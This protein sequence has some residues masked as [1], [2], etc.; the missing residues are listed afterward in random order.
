MLKVGWSL[1]LTGLFLGY[2]PCL[3]TCGP[4]LI[5]YIAATK[6]NAGKGFRTYLIFSL[7][8]VFVYLILGFL[9]GVLGEWVLHRFYESQTLKILFLFFGF[10]LV[11]VGFFLMIEKFP[12]GQKCHFLIQTHLQKKDTKN[13]ILFGLF[14]SLAPCLPLAA[15]LGYIALIADHW[16]KGLFYMAAFAVGTVISPMVFLSLAA[17]WLARVLE[18]HPIASRILKILSG[19]VITWLGIQLIFSVF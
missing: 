19:A 7:T 6:E 11:A 9:A 10:F 4:L 3:L 12:L 16:T 18:K 17:G 14:V 2:G 13:I 8:R 5:P 15:V 1:F